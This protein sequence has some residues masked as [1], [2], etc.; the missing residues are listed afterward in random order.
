[1]KPYFKI[2]YLLVGLFFAFLTIRGATGR[3]P[4]FF[5]IFE[6]LFFLF[7]L[8]YFLFFFNYLVSN[9]MTD[10]SIYHSIGFAVILTML[11]IDGIY[12]LALWPVFLLL[13]TSSSYMLVRGTITA[14]KQ[15][16][17]KN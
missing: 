15:K 6:P 14:F 2:L 3:G 8:L 16:F 11:S 9:R 12:I 10:Y 5:S 13:L 1:M 4:V 7:G 17:S